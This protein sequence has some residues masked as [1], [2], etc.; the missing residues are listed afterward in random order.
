MLFRSSGRGEELVAHD[1]EQP[2]AQVGAGLPQ[3]GIGEPCGTPSWTRS[4]AFAWSRCP[5]WAVRRMKGSSPSSAASLPR[6]PKRRRQTLF[7]AAG[8]A[9]W[10]VIGRHRTKPSAKNPTAKRGAGVQGT[11]PYSPS[12]RQP[13]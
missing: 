11:L 1:R 2:A 10:T 8:L 7:S 12:K 13:M 3:F 4:P 9:R 6:S 5:R